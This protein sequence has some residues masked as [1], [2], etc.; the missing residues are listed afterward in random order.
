VTGS[1]AKV[2]DTGRDM[3]EK[4]L[5]S[6]LE[7]QK[8]IGPEGLHEALGGGFPESVPENNPIWIGFL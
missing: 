2:P 6:F 5:E 3:S 8:P 7:A 1:Q 4:S